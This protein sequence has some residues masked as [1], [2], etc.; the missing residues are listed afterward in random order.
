MKFGQLRDIVD[1]QQDTSAD[2]ASAEDFSGDPLFADVPCKITLIGGDESYR[3]RQLEAHVSAVVEMHDLPGIKPT[4]RLDVTGG[5]CD[6]RVFNI[7]SVRPKD[8]DGRVPMLE[9]YCRELTDA[10]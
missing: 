8:Y 1:I 9:L 10:R 4:M 2:G 3:G 6:G 5:F 7:Q